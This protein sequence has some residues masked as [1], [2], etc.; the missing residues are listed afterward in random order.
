MLNIRT[1]VIDLSEKTTDGAGSIELIR[2]NVNLSIRYIGA[3]YMG[4]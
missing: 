1:E 2:I 4:I 3:M